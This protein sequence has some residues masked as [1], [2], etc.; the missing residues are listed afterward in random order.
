MPKVR[1]VPNSAVRHNWPMKKIDTSIRIDASPAIVW[2]ILTDF[3]AYPGWN[4]FITNIEGIVRAGERLTIRVAPPGQKG[5]AFRPHV[6]V[7]EPERQLRWKGRL[8]VPGLFDGE[9]I[10]RIEPAADGIRFYHLEQFTGLLP[11]IMPAS[12]F[13]A[14]REGFEAMNGALKQRAEA[15][16]QH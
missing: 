12:S 6:L 9:H 4:P 1:L 10:F 8:I 16:K 5:M 3:A 15:S 11:H 2:G 7:A 13:E 14:I